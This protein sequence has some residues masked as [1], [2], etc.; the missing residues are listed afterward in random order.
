MHKSYISYLCAVCLLLAN[1][2]NDYT[3]NTECENGSVQCIDT[4]GACYKC[5]EV[6][7]N[8]YWEKTVCTAGFNDTKTGCNE[9]NTYCKYKRHD[10]GTCECN[11]HCANNCNEDGSCKCI[12]GWEDDGSCKHA[13]GCNNEYD[14]ENRYNINGSCK[15]HKNCKNECNSDGSCICPE[16]CVYGCKPDGSCKSKCANGV[17]VNTKDGT[18][19][20]SDKCTYG[21]KP[22]GSCNK[23]DIDCKNGS[24]ELGECICTGCVNGCHSDGSCICQGCVNGCNSDGSCTCPCEDNDCTSNGVCRTLGLCYDD[25]DCLEYDYCKESECRCGNTYYD[26][27]LCIPTDSNHNHILDSKE[28]DALGGRDEFLKLSVQECR[29]DEDCRNYKSNKNLFCDSFADYRCSIKCDDNS[30][31]M[32]GFICRGDGRCA[33][34]FFTTVWSSELRKILYTQNEPMK[35]VTQNENCNGLEICWDWK[36][37]GDNIF[38]QV[39]E[40]ECLDGSI[41]YGKIT[42]KVKIIEKHYEQ[43]SDIPESEFNKELIIKVRG[44]L[45]NFQVYS[46]T[47]Y[48]TTMDAYVPDYDKYTKS[49][50]EV[51]SFG[52]VEIANDAFWECRNLKSVSMIDIPDSKAL[53]SM[54]TMFRNCCS[55]NSPLEMWDVSNVENME[56]TFDMHNCMNEGISIPQF[57]SPLNRWNVGNVTNMAQMFGYSSY[58]QPLDNW[59]V[60][61]VDNFTNMFRNSKFNQPLNSWNLS[62]TKQL[63]MTGMFAENQFFNQPLNRWNVSRV[64]NMESMFLGATSFNQDISAWD[65]SNVTNM[66]TMFN[67]ASA[68]VND[69]SRWTPKNVNNATGIFISSGIANNKDLCCSIISAWKKYTWFTDLQNFFGNL[70]FTCNDSI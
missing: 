19:E 68:F 56:F 6:A 62:T 12:V 29:K 42:K 60:S 39:K 61:N 54:S 22:D 13:L 48:N 57:N 5:I 44:K 18:C 69:L 4:E 65:V 11:V 1:A 55:F 15:C 46:E 21:C 38:E 2:C 59:D 30:D 67:R 49:L 28:Y 41:N 63:Y 66:I 47:Y 33:S 58:N 7:S 43:I 9:I 50:L 10:D 26:M 35:I 37:N 27:N 64:Y 20:C 70:A 53:K 36:D 51:R 40:D 8:T 34:E 45:K 32:N 24:N 25:D 16:S 3:T 17:E 52:Q 31:C 14:E 23:I